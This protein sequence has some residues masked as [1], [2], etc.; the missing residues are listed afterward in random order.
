MNLPSLSPY[1]EK[2][3]IS[4]RFLLALVI[5][6]Y[7]VHSGNVEGIAGTVIG[8]YFGTHLPDPDPAPTA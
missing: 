8:Y 2:E 3:L 1:I 7:F 4:K 5:L 6:F